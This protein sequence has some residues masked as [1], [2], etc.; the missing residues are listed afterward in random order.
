MGLTS[1]RNVQDMPV[2]AHSIPPE[3][4][5]S[6]LGS[7]LQGISSSESN[8]RLSTYGFNELPEGAG[9]NPFLLFFQQFSSPL[10]WLLLGAMVVSFFLH[11]TFDTIVIAVIVLLNAI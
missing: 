5:L 3:K 8:R 6:Q 10:V 9:I 2:A 1:K 11:E 7:S 4:L